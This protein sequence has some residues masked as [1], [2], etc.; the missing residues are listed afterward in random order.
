MSDF[1]TIEEVLEDLQDGCMV[2]LVDER[3]QG[4][5]GAEI[6]GEGALMMV[7]ELVTP[8]SITFMSRQAGSTPSV[9]ASQEHLKALELD[10][11]IPATKSGRHAA[12]VVPINAV[13]VQ[14]TGVSAQ[15]RALTVRC[16]A[17]PNSS[18]EDFARPG[19]VMPLQAQAGGVLKRAGHTE[20][21][22]D[23]ARMAAFQPV[24]VI[25]DILDD[26]GQVASTPYL[27]EFA[28]KHGFKIATIKEPDR[29]PAPQRKTDRARSQSRNAHRLR[30]V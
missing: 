2:V 11:I 12:A 19:Q 18:S 28:Q 3:G 5:D 26:D 6:V 14:G 7:A 17:D 22:V 30:R 8:E 27:L 4:L 21:A 9:P 13:D 15:D 29:P 1:N 25:A 20:A 23:L 24:A 10:L 16:L